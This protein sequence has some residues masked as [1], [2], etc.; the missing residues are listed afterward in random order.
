[1]LDKHKENELN[2]K[3]KKY[4]NK[5]DIDINFINSG[6]IFHNFL[7]PTLTSILLELN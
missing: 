3:F 6:T 1:M 4:S 7:K 5:V 2:N